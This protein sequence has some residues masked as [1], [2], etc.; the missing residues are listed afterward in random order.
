MVPKFLLEI[1]SAYC[2]SR[3]LVIKREP[4]IAPADLK[5]YTASPLSDHLME[6]EVLKSINLK[7]DSFR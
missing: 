4:T 5:P 3:G 2:V 6:D 7:N 1:A